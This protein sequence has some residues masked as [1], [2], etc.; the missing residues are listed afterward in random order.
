[1]SSLFFANKV[2]SIIWAY[3]FAANRHWV[4]AFFKCTFFGDDFLW[5]TQG[6]FSGKKMQNFKGVSV[7]NLKL[8]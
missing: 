5:V 6:D 8:I 2:K 3:S 4:F 7:D 1:M